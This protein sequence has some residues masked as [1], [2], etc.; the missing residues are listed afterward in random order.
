MPH[1]F[2]VIP[3]NAHLRRSS[4]WS[5]WQNTHSVQWEQTHASMQETHKMLS[6]SGSGNL[7]ETYGILE[8]TWDQSTQTGVIYFVLEGWEVVPN[9][10]WSEWKSDRHLFETNNV[11][12]HPSISE[13]NKSGNSYLLCYFEKF[14]CRNKEILDFSIFPM[15]YFHMAKLKSFA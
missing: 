3:I 9:R 1:G 2:A 4:H 8:K 5:W 15:K 11:A 10:A 12:L 14:R 7:M 6:S 13:W